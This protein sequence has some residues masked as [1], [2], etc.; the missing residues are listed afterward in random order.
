M[1]LHPTKQLLLTWLKSFLPCRL[2]LSSQNHH[3]F[4]TEPKI[5]FFFLYSSGVGYKPSSLNTLLQPCS[6]NTTINILRI[7]SHTHYCIHSNYYTVKLYSYHRSTEWKKSP[8]TTE[9][10]KETIKWLCMLKFSGRETSKQSATFIK[11]YLSSPLHY[12]LQSQ[13]KIQFLLF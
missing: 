4:L 5:F 13:T 9:N 3:C 1:C 7:S 6:A 2:C 8:P 11:N 10:K 12:I